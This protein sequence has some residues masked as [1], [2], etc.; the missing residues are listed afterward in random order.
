VPAER[1][2]FL[3][4]NCRPA[5]ETFWGEGR[6]Y[7]RT[8]AAAAS[9]GLTLVQSSGRS[10]A[11]AAAAETIYWYRTTHG[12]RAAS[13]SRDGSAACGGVI[14][15]STCGPCVLPV[16]QAVT[17]RHRTERSATDARW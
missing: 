6:S 8:P 5:E 2:G 12:I 1:G 14:V 17:T 16:Q 13:S 11:A 10:L 9:T 7:N 3:P 4:V 15:C